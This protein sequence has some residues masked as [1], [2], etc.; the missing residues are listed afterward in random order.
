MKN[1]FS[2]KFVL[3]Y[4][5]LEDYIKTAEEYKKHKK[6]EVKQEEVERGVIIIEIM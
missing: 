3:E 4:L 2:D 5:Y 1:D 6:E